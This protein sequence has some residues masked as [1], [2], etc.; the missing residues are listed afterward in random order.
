MATVSPSDAQ[1][2]F[3]GCR[4]VC[5]IFYARL[6]KAVSTYSTRISAY[7]PRPD[8]HGIP[9][10]QE[11]SKSM[12][13]MIRYVCIR[14]CYLLDFEASHWWQ[15]HLIITSGKHGCRL[16]RF[17]ELLYYYYWWTLR[18]FTYILIL[19][20]YMNALIIIYM[21]ALIIICMRYNANIIVIYNSSSFLDYYY[22]YWCHIIIRYF[23][24]IFI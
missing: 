15:V 5:L 7:R 20:T 8:R 4:R 3:G 10:R 18:S 24:H 9:L 6:M 11:T 2:L 21:N 12:S 17:M 23:N 22:Y 1:T 13:V 16:I 14:I 19:N